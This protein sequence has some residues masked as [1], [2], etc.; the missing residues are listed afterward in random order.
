MKSRRISL[1]VVILLIVIVAMIAVWSLAAPDESKSESVVSSKPTATATLPALD[2][3][4]TPLPAREVDGVPYVLA[5]PIP[6]SIL[7]M[8]EYNRG[9]MKSIDIHTSERYDICVYTEVLYGRDRICD[10]PPALNATV[11]PTPNPDCR[12]LAYLLG[13]DFRPHIQ[14]FLDDKL[15]SGGVLGEENTLEISDYLGRDS[16]YLCYRVPLESGVHKMK[17]VFE[18]EP[19]NILDVGEWEFTLTP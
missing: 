13:T 8:E 2:I 16:Y 14:I 7:S 19:E 3:D 4:L 17:Y 6:G 1:V 18:W 12:S 5:H 10:L 15:I 11:T 9:M